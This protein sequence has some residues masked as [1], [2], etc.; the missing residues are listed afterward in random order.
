MKELYVSCLLNSNNSSGV[1]IRPI[2]LYFT[3]L[4]TYECTHNVH[5]HACTYVRTYNE[6][7]LL[8]TIC[9]EDHL[10][11]VATIGQSVNY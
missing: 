10:S 3:Y 8:K 6:T 4:R 7:C 11:T 5:L 2:E 1:H 9:T